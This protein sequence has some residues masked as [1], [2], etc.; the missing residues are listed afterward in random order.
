VDHFVMPQDELAGTCES[1]GEDCST[2]GRTHREG[3]HHAVSSGTQNEKLV[4]PWSGI[5][6][7]L[8]A[9]PLLSEAC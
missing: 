3:K 9:I 4:F 2:V 8:P 7:P 5:G 6:Y 1:F